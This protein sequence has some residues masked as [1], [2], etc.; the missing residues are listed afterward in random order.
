MKQNPNCLIVALPVAS[1]RIRIKLSEQP[2]ALEIT[3]MFLLKLEGSRNS[4]KT[5]MSL[6]IRK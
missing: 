5:L 2:D 1:S 6:R 3:Y 4:I